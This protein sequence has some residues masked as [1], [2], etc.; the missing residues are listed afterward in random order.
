MDR[1][2]QKHDGV[3]ARVRGCVHRLAVAWTIVAGSVSSM[4]GAIVAPEP[5]PC[6]LVRLTKT[7]FDNCRCHHHPAF[8]V[9]HHPHHALLCLAPS[10]FIQRPGWTLACGQ[11][12]S[13]S[14]W[15]SAQRGRHPYTGAANRPHDTHTP[16]AHPG[17]NRWLAASPFSRD[18]PWLLLCSCILFL[19]A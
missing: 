7:W 13:G 15:T 5:L 6:H 2:L 10:G 19:P 3:C 14:Q 11:C 12:T 8:R 1:A 9:C 4:L 17:A 16:A 18:H